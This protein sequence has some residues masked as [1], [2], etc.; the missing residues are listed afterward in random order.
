[1]LSTPCYTV[2]R[3]PAN[4]LAA[5]KFTIA[6]KHSDGKNHSQIAN[7]LRKFSELCA[8]TVGIGQLCMILAASVASTHRLLVIIALIAITGA[9]VPLEFP[10]N[11]L[12]IC[13]IIPR[14]G[15]HL[16]VPG[17]RCFPHP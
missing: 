12:L 17:Q 13:A 4:A 10:C 9:A 11:H 5:H 1:M 3:C 14:P 2:F 8:V 15:G 7:I 16:G 6:R